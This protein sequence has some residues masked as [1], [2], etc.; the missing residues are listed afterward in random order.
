[1]IKVILLLSFSL[2]METY[3]HKKEKTRAQEKFF[4]LTR[5]NAVAL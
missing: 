4:L 3:L 5:E 1:M 2:M